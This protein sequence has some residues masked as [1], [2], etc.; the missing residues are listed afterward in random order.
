M[1]MQ[2]ADGALNLLPALPDAWAN[3]TISGIR[4]RGGFEIVSMEWKDGK[5]AKAVIKSTLG[6]NCRLRLPNSARLVGG[7]LKTAKGANTNFFYQNEETAKPIISAQA[8]LKPVGN[9]ETLLYDFAT[10]A[11]KTYIVVGL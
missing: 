3:G 7:T 1:L 2:S 11:G 8:Q 10:T 9:K 6:G 5:L 4:A